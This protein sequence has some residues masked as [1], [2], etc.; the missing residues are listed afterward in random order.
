M[1]ERSL[2]LIAGHKIYRGGDILRRVW[3]KPAGKAA[4]IVMSWAALNA[5]GL[6][7]LVILTGLVEF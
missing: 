1:N 4:F 2:V 5:I 3:S 7:L 6:A